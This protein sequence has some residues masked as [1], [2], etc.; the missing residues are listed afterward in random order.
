MEKKMKARTAARQKDEHGRYLPSAH[1]I[2]LDPINKIRSAQLFNEIVQPW[3]DLYFYYKNVSC[4]TCEDYRQFRAW[5]GVSPD[6][7]EL[8][9]K[10]Y[11]HPLLPR[12]RLLLL[13]NW[14]K[15]MPSQD[16]GSSSFRLSRP[17]YRKYLWETLDYLNLSMTEV[18]FRCF[19]RSYLLSRSKRKIAL[20]QKPKE[21]NMGSLLE[22]L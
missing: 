1:L 9:Y 15:A 2:R 5:V 21:M 13:L 6:V 22:Y 10:K 18:F 12:D 19:S 8:I 7:A 3:L 17:T 4:S 14:L 16:E 20:N 11:L